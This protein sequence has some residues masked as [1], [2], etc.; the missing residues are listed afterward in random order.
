MANLIALPE[1]ADLVDLFRLYPE[2]A[3]VALPLAQHILRSDSPLTVMQRELIFA[4]GSGLNACHYCHGA[5][6]AAAEALGLDTSLM[7]SLLED[8]DTA[9]IDE[10]FK[11][12]LKYVKKLT[13]TP[14]KVT[15]ADADAVRAAGWS[16]D[17][18]HSAITVCALHNFFNRWVDGSG[19]DGSDAYVRERGEYLADNGYLPSNTDRD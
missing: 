18:L 5:H 19:V 13:Q 12:I 11:P 1:P 4:F 14:S 15:R 6:T 2:T 7:A 3:K 8:I 10:P 16:D 17:A 9:P